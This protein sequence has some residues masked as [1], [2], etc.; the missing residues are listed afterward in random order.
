META[1]DGTSSDNQVS[2]IQV[3]STLFI[4]STVWKSPSLL[5]KLLTL[6]KNTDGRAHLWQCIDVS[7]VSVWLAYFGCVWL[8]EQTDDVMGFPIISWLRLLRPA[9]QPRWVRRQIPHWDIRAVTWQSRLELA[10]VGRIINNTITV[11]KSLLHTCLLYTSPSP[12][13]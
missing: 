8:V 7:A 6:A 3:T 1:S 10:Y 2:D 9:R 5:N 4:F 12:R 11:N 13:D